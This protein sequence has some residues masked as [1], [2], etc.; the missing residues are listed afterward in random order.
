MC[1]LTLE[2]LR[3][4]SGVVIVENKKV[5][6]F[7]RDLSLSFVNKQCNVPHCIAKVDFYTRVEQVDSIFFYNHKVN[8]KRTAVVAINEC[9]K[10]VD[11]ARDA[12]FN[13]AP[14]D[15]MVNAVL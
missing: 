12:G 2:N 3:V 4:K 1:V 10:V 14:R 8:T 6:G 15:E 7:R 13:F 11:E 5:R 9:L